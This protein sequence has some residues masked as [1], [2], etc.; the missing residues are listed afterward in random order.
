MPNNSTN[1]IIL[2]RPDMLR[3]LKKDVKGR[4]IIYTRQEI[5]D[6]YNKLLSLTQF[7]EG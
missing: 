4:N 6:I 1:C 2:K 7:T 5:E 3:Q